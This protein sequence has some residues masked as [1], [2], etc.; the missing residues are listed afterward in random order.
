[1]RQWDEHFFKKL[2]VRDFV[3]G[4][5]R[6]GDSRSGWA[7]LTRNGS[8]SMNRSEG[9]MAKVL[10]SGQMTEHCV[11]GPPPTGA[12]TNKTHGGNVIRGS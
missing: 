8:L 6:A 4:T 12:K 1:M 2:N 5:S 11:R 10:G 9:F 7:E 3:Q